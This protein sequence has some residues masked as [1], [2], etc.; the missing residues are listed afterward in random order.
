[1]RKLV[2]RQRERTGVKPEPGVVSD[3][4]GL[5]RGTTLLG[6]ETVSIAV[7]TATTVYS[8]ASPT[9][10]IPG[11]L[12][13]VLIG[14]AQLISILTRKTMVGISGSYEEAGDF[15]W[16]LIGGADPNA[17]PTSYRSIVFASGVAAGAYGL[18]TLLPELASGPVYEVSPLM[19]VA[20]GVLMT[21][22]SRMAGG[23]TSGHGISGISLLSVSSIV[24]IMT[25]F[26]TAALVTPLVH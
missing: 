25:T 19:A 26:A 7:I 8:A 5:S 17:K 20:G 23:C 24:T 9:A 14:G 2:K 10:K 3:Q 1:V 12:G 13:G 6:L 15:F 4:F 21:I 11:A 18:L 16:W 22:G